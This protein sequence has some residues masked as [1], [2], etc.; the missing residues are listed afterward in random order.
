MVLYSS[1]GRKPWTG[2]SG[3]SQ[4]VD[5]PAQ[6]AKF[7]MGPWMGLVAQ[8]VEDPPASAGDL[9]SISKLL[10]R[11]DWPPTPLFLPGGSHG[12]RSLVD[13]SPW[14]HKELDRIEKLTH[15][16]A[17]THTQTHTQTHART[18]THTHARMHTQT[19]AQR[20]RHACTCMHA[21]AHMCMHTHMH[22]HSDRAR[23]LA[24]AQDGPSSASPEKPP[25]SER[26]SLRRF[27]ST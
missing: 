10:S 20:E 12:Q 8:T 18:H 17:H 13:Y 26:R 9:S 2:W 3:P 22:A 1:E 11:K 23:G 21:H 27:G 24:G 15:T 6:S 14:G 16:R 25:G 4:S 19:H 5:H 7:P